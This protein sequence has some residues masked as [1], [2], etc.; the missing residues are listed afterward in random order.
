MAIVGS[1]LKK[2]QEYES[3]AVAA[4]LQGAQKEKLL[5]TLYRERSTTW[6]AGRSAADRRSSR[7]LS[8]A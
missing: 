2:G 5:V 1:E 8:T 3:P 6:Y 4:L 7:Q